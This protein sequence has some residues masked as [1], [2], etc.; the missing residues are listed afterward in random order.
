PTSVMAG[1]AFTG[2]VLSEGEPVADA[3]VELNLL[4]AEM[5]DGRFGDLLV[6]PPGISIVGVT[7]ANGYFTFGIPFAGHWSVTALGTGPQNFH[8]FTWLYQ[9]AIIWFEAHD[10]R[11]PGEVR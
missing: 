1:Q 7:D 4:N 8:E 10:F 2:L 11:R 6:E 5:L 9:D 3:P